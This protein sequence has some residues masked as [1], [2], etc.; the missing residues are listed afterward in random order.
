LIEKSEKKS[1]KRS[2]KKPE[3]SKSGL[4]KITT[5]ASGTVDLNSLPCIETE[6]PFTKVNYDK[7]QLNQKVD[8]VEFPS[9]FEIITDSLSLRKV[10]IKSKW[11]EQTNYKLSI[12]PGAFEDLYKMPHDTII[13]SF[14]TQKLE[15]YGKLTLKLSGVKIP[16][17]VQL[18]SMDKV[19]VEK[20]AVSD[21]NIVFDYLQ[22]KSYTLKIIYDEN[23]DKR[24]TSGD[25]IKKKQPEK[26]IYYKEEIK[27]RS[28]W[29]IDI[30]WEIE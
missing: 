7:I 20:F 29:D 21:G 23:G 27:M 26:V 28:N 11:V 12:F 1:E 9:K 6:F 8:T 14:T 10:S 13:S 22:P 3:K 19:E 5:N 16:V 4:M 24:W 17:I 15:Y 30:V 2:V 18:L 25:L